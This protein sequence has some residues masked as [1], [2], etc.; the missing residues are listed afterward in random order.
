M[1]SADAHRIARERG[2]SPALYLLAR[3][4]LTPLFR[5]WLRLRSAGSERVPLEGPVILAP[6][7]KSEWDPFLVASC[8]PRRM[9]FMAKAELFSPPLA[10]PLLWLGAFPVRR[11]RSDSEAIATARSILEQGGALLLFPEGKLVRKPFELGMPRRGVGRLALETGAPSCRW[12]SAARTGSSG[13][14]A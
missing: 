7:H 5:I 13:D 6:N 12:R 2:V 3:L 11:G 14:R 4:V 10:R 9:S 8:I 1:S